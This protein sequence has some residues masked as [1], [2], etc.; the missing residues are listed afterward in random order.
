MG[1]PVGTSVPSVILVHT[2]PIP[3]PGPRQILIQLFT[4]GVGGWDESVRDGSWRLHP[5]RTKFPL[6]LGTDGAGIVI[7]KGKRVRRFALRDRVWA[8]ESAN[9]KGGF[10]AEFV[11]IDERKAGRVPRRLDLL[12]A[13]A[14]AVTALTALQ[15]I[16]DTLHVRRR[17]TVLIFGASGAVGTL[18]IQF[19]KRRGARVLATASGRAASMLVRRLGA[20]AV[21]DARS[22]KAIEKLRE[23]APKGIDAVLALAGGDE[24]ERC[25][26]FMRE[27]GR[28]AYPNGIEPEPEQRGKFTIDSYDVEAGSREFSRLAR[29]AEEARLRVPIAA[30]YPLGRADDAQR[31]LN[32]QV[33]GRIVLRL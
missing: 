16:D 29:A 3:Q 4:A 27:G 32:K 25:L 2:V 21:I 18:A 10:Y 14:G 20:E 15:G 13:G 26:D 17:E 24:L 11:A 1:E 28:V 30:T 6:I 31:R 22:S 23:L 19:A 5:G 7:A 33:V 9:P 12:Q 8:Y